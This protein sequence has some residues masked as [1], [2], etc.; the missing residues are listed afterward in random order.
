MN[1]LRRGAVF[2]AG[3]LAGL[4][5]TGVLLLITAKPRGT[6]VQLLP[7]PT[8]CQLRIHVAGAVASPGVYLLPPDS[9]VQQAIDAA[10]GPSP[11]GVMS[12]LNLAAPLKDGQQVYLP[13]LT[14][15]PDANLSAPP[16][17]YPQDPRGLININTA[18]LVELELLPGI[19]PSLAQRIIDYRE[20]HGPFKSR[21]SL[22]KV[23]GIGNAKLEAIFDLITVQ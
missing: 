13:C 14:E 2:L 17:N 7:P 9:I 23:P 11:E 12:A 6:P 4:L 3:L 10:G 20:E 19:G 22:T 15:Q 16:S 8:P 21:D 5:S 18:S 1:I